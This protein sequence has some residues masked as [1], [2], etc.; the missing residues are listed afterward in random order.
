MCKKQGENQRGNDNAGERSGRQGEKCALGSLFRKVALLGIASLAAWLL[1]RLAQSHPEAVERI[2][3]RGIY[4]LWGQALSTVTGLLP[5]SL[6]EVLLFALPALLALGVVQ[7]ARRRIAWRRL[8]AAGCAC[9][10]AGTWSFPS[11]GR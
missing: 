5:V 2:Y 4:P 1:T 11:A 10:F 9:P 3:S 7:A 8:V 6:S